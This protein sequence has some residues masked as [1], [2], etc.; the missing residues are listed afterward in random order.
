MEDTYAKNRHDNGAT[1]IPARVHSGSLL[2]LCI[3]LHDTK[4]KCDAGASSPRFL[5]RSEVFISAQKF[6]QVSCK[7]GMTVRFR[8]IK[9]S[10]IYGTLRL[11]PGHAHGVGVHP[12]IINK[13]P[14]FTQIFLFWTECKR[15]QSQS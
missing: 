2:W 12:L 6:F 7:R 3:R 11:A 9:S 4:A 10:S 1:F 13:C 14:T 8:F 5:C 15:K